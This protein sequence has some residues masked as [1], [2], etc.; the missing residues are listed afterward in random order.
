MKSIASPI[1]GLILTCSLIYAM[2][3]VTKNVSYWIFYEDLVTN[4]I[5]QMVKP[6]AL[7]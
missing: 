2:Y 3:W 1:V 6:E 7:K 5:Q 4:T